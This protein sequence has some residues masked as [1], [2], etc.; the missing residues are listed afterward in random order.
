MLIL[1]FAETND[2]FK[3]TS[4]H[5]LQGIY[6]QPHLDADSANSRQIAFVMLRD[7]IFRVLAK[8]VN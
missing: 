2:L 7:A 6:Q 8:L 3:V 5:I 1:D 4:Q